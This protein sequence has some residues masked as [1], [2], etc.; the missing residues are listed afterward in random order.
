[1]IVDLNEEVEQARRA[2]A[3]AADRRRILIERHNVLVS[4]IRGRS[5]ATGPVPA[6]AAPVEPP[7]EVVGPARPE[8]S[9]RTVQN[10]LFVLG[11]LLLGS[12][13]IVFTAVAWANFG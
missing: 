9:G 4:E 11:G 13:A 8:S 5:E 10:V 1:M 6:A 3:G 12:A 7:T 2:F